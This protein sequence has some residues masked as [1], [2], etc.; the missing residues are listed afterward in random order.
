MA[1]LIHRG[2]Q[3]EQPFIAGALGKHGMELYVEGNELAQ[4]DVLLLTP[5]KLKFVEFLQLLIGG[6]PGRS[7][8]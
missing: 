3:A 6:I 7:M 4:V 2:S 1:L 5:D 8:C